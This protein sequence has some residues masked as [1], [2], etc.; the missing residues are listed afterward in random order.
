[1]G[2]RMQ[3][4]QLRRRE[5]IALMGS[6]VIA[7]PLAFLAACILATG[8]AA[9]QTYPTRPITL[10]V[11]YPPGGATDAIAR[12]MQDSMSQSLGQQ[13]VIENIGGAG[14]MIAAGRAARA[15]PDGYTVLLHQVALAAAMT[16]Y[17][18]LAFDAEKDFVTIGPVNTAATTIAARPTL[19]PNTMTELVRWMK[20]PGQNA[21]MAHAGAGSFGHLCG[22][23]FAQEVGAKV[24]QIPY[25][26]AGPALNDLMAGHADLSCQSAAAA[27]PLIKA[28]K[29]KAYGILAK[30]RFDGLPDLP[31]LGEVGYKKLDL[32]FWHMLFAP[33]G[34]PRPVVDRLNAALRHALSDAKVTDTFA[35]SGMDLYPVNEWTPEAG[36]ALLKGGIKL[37]GDVI[38][39]NNITAQ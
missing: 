28:G 24:D 34:T 9:A 15:A 23:L 11:P 36:A 22:V 33:A 31:T 25:R 20:E 30:T 6:A 3:R 32:D 19:P 2:D 12:I 38:R 5:F 18:N 16:L 13:I 1:M 29:L 37:W 17:P 8:S 21:K 39:A 27:G 35:K 26:G 7:W 10:V 14:G 4:E